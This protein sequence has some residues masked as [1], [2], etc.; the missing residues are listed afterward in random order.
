MERQ[1]SHDSSSRLTTSR[2]IF[3]RGLQ[4]RDSGSTNFEGQLVQQKGSQGLTTLSNP[5]SFAVADL[6]F[7]HGLNGNSQ[8]TWSK[9]GESTF[10]PNTWLPDDHAFRDVRIHTFG[11][12]SAIFQESAIL[13]IQDFARSLL[14]AIQDSPAIPPDETV[15]TMPGKHHLLTWW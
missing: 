3:N 5:N 10:W 7:V 6:V 2:S 9:N 14:G 1:T 13:N 8:N 12:A 4:W 11:Y 15:C